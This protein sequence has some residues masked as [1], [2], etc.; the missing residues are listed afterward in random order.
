MAAEPEVEP[1]IDA[2]RAPE[3]AAVAGPAAVAPPVGPTE[4]TWVAAGPTAAPDPTVVADVPVTGAA[5]GAVPHPGQAAGWPPASAPPSAGTLGQPGA[6]VLDERGNL[7]GGLLGLVGA[8]LVVVGV[9]L[10]W[11][12]VAGEMVSGWAASDDAKVLLG[13]AGVATLAGALV[14]GGARSLV[15]RILLVVLGVVAIGFAGFE[16]LSVNGVE[17]LDPSP[18]LGLFVGLLGGFVL[19]VAGALTRHRRFR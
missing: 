7:P 13:V 5:P 19:L 1:T 14:V 18:G 10:P 9:V 2:R 3:P 16:V 8:A 17:D 11:M 6:P 4:P 15:L 12:D